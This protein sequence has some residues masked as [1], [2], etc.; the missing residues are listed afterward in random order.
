MPHSLK[1]L[2]ALALG[3][4]AGCAARAHITP[5]H[6]QSS[7]AV[8]ARQAP[9]V[10]EVAGPVSGLDSQEASI[11]SDTYRASLS[12]KDAPPKEDPYLMVA[13]PPRTS[14]RAMLPPPSVPRE[15]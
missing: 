8:F 2:A 7:R 1:L 15:R 11:V 9:P 5:T 3:A 12:P 13:P 14:G 6:G 4:A 10:A